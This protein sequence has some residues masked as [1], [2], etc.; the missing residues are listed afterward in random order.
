MTHL[1]TNQ[2]PPPITIICVHSLSLDVSASF[3][4]RHVASEAVHTEHKASGNEA[5][6]AP[7]VATSARDPRTTY[8][9]KRAPNGFLRQFHVY[10]VLH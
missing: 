8:R 9:T 1:S 10:N 6:H 7:I 2:P 4:H 5:S 3:F